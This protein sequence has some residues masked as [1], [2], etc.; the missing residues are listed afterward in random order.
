M[1]LRKTIVISLFMHIG[2]FTAATL[3]SFNPGAGGGRPQES[4]IVIVRL[5]DSLNEG[6]LKDSLENIR[7]LHKEAHRDNLVRIIHNVQRKKIIT[8]H[9]MEEQTVQEQKEVSRMG[10]G[11][12]RMPPGEAFNEE[13]VDAGVENLGEEGSAEDPLIEEG[14]LIPSIDGTGVSINAEASGGDINRSAEIITLIRRCIEKVRVYP[15]MARKRGI[16]GVVYVS[17]RVTPDGMPVDVRIVQSSGSGIL[18]KGAI[19]IIK[20]AGP[21]PL[22]SGVVEVPI[23]FRL[24]KDK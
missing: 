14:G 7:P 1:K 24:R 15:V 11:I 4:A 18:D 16:E 6:K 21:Y 22:F 17:F 20:R 19:K 8:A 13:V 2:I 3:L 10:D 23:S 5:I 9:P 12:M